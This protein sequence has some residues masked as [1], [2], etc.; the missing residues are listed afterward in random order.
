MK[1]L[2]SGMMLTLL[3]LGTLTLTLDVQPAKSSPATITVP[4]DYATIQAAINAA[5]SGDTIYVRNGIYQEHIEVN[6]PVTLTGESNQNTI[7]ESLGIHITAS[8]TAIENFHIIGS[9]GLLVMIDGRNSLC[10]NNTIR[11][12][13]FMQTT[14][15]DDGVL[16]I[17]TSES[18]TVAGNL[19][20]IGSGNGHGMALLYSSDHNTIDNNSITGG[21]VSI[22]SDFSDYNVF[23]NNYLAGQN[24]TYA[25]VSGIGALTLAWTK[26]DIARGN[27]FIQNDIGFSAPFGQPSCSVYNNNF[28]NNTQQAL[29]ASGSQVAFDK[30]YL[31][32]GNYWSDYTGVDLY[33]G[34]HQNITGSDGIG[35][36]PYIIDANNLDNYPLMTP[37]I[38]VH[39][40]AVTNVTLSK[41]VV[42]QGYDMNINVTVANQGD[43]IETFNVITFITMPPPLP[44][45][46]F[47]NTTTVS[48]DV[49]QNMTISFAWNTTGLDIG[50]YTVSATAGYN[51]FRSDKILVTIPGDLNGDLQV[52][53]ADFMILAN[54][55]GSTPQMPSKWNPNADINGDGKVSL[56]DLVIMAN[57]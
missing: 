2:V 28:I 3:M 39:D 43:Y 15:G 53:L 57:H 51:T 8:N 21:W 41:T 6:K 22:Y 19:M 42:G 36:T 31:C 20:V 13:T 52:S 4:D 49:G 45:E 50:N 11:N 29:I 30:G 24:G 55:Y 32:G 16:D 10:S 26:G 40:I 46:L 12:N 47:I 14:Q 37:H 23:S 17:L 38:G 7:I 1:K 48:L 56:T 9:D 25:P 27:T 35:D 54:A 18:D 34:P 5:N 33:S 44:L